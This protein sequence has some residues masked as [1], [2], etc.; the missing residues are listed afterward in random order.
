MDDQPAAGEDRRMMGTVFELLRPQW[1]W[2]LALLPFFW[3]RYGRLPAAAIAWRSLIVL[4]VVAALA[5]P[6]IIKPTA[7]AKHAER[8]FAFDVSRSVPAEM[9][10]W[11]ARQERVPSAGDR[12]FL[13]GGAAAETANWKQ[14]LQTPFYNLRPER[15]NL[16][17]LFSALGDLSP[18][19]RS[20]FLFT[21]G[22]ENEGSAERLLPA[23]AE[24]GIKVYPILPPARMPVA[25]VAVK[26]VIAPAEAV[27]GEAVTVTVSM[28]NGDQRE[29]DGNLTLK[30]EGRPIKTELVRLRPGSQLVGY[31]VAVGDGP[32]EAFEAEFTPSRP[33]AD[34]LSEDNRATAWI[35]VQAKEKVLLINGRPGEGRYVEE[36]LKRRGFDVT[37]IP[38]GASVPA[39]IGY[40]LIVLN[41][42][43]KDHLSAGYLSAL[44]RHTSAGNGLVVLGDDT[45]LTPGYKQTPLAA[46]LPVDFIEPKENE[47]Q[48]EKTRAV[49]LV[50][51]KSRSM[52]PEANPPHENRILYAKEISKRVISQLNDNDFIG[53]IGFDTAP[54]PVVQMDNVGNLRSTFAR[55]VDRLVP[56]GN[57]DILSALRGA[58]TQLQRQTADAKYAIL[59]TDADRVGGRPSEYTELVTRMRDEGKI[60]VS[61]VGVGRG[62]DEALVKRIAVYGG[63]SFHIAKD[64][65]DFP[66]FRFEGEQKSPASAPQPPAQQFTPIPGRNS[67]IL[68]PLAAQAFPRVRGFVEAVAKPAARVDLIVQNKGKSS[69]ILASWNYG[70]GKVVVL[71]IDQSGRW[72]RDWIAWSGLERFWGRIF[73][74]SKPAREA[75]PPHEARIDRIGDQV[76][77]D[78]YVYS[79]E[80]DGNPFRYSYAGPRGVK[81]EGVLKRLAPGHYQAALPFTAAGDYRIEVKEDRPSRT[82]GYPVLGYTRPP[83]ITSEAP[84]GDV[85]VALLERIARATGGSINPSIE[86]DA[87]GQK[88]PPTVQPLNAYLILAAALVFL[89]EGFF[90]RFVLRPV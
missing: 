84:T 70:K 23:L 81:S 6:R 33:D 40:G 21:D 67:E 13:F 19:E 24:A 39:P 51:D 76:F 56:K 25:N 53:V 64:L 63:G 36:L 47:P 77:L 89:A 66:V 34:L 48:P 3:M 49:L 85:N 1:L 11:M 80:S 87:P 10:R 5:D 83:E 88:N 30:R 65:N 38:P 41:N 4:L 69:P 7:S 31:Q 75:L 17:G 78:F 22:R 27:K 62:V 73:D 35:S 52:D 8:V 20:V 72:S 29:I 60:L 15:T 2:L 28:E 79:P 58:M 57:T 74:W 37:P 50:I 16:E 61:A 18:A 45:A 43:D 46:A 55:D 59:I 14:Q 26:K 42:V 86:S 44:E 12:V 90:R 82:I 32:L 68:A 71:A 54:F 9:R